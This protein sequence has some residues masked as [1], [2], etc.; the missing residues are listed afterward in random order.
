MSDLFS[1]TAPLTIRLPSG[2]TSLM[3]EVFR[4]AD[5]LLY[6]DLWWQQGDPDTHFH[7]IEG[8]VSGDGPWKIN[9]H[10]I[11]VLGCQG[12]DPELASEWSA[13]NSYITSHVS[14][15]PVPEL[16]EA[17]ARKMGADI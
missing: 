12:T 14:D 4:H 15:Y 7:L 6:F 5:G 9:D 11:N 3:A 8:E 10:V 17:I 1:V 13:W 16:V 2:E